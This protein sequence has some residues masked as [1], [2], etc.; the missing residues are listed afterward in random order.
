MIDA[1]GGGRTIAAADIDFRL[2]Q[3]RK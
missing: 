2:R 3:L 1:A